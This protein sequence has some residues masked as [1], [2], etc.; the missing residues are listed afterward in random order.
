MTAIACWVNSEEQE[1]VWAVSDSR[2]TQFTSHQQVS[3]LTDHCPKL[4]TIPVSVIRSVDNFRIFPEKIFEF[5]FGFAGSTVIGINVKEILALS[6]SQLN[7]IGNNH[8]GQQLPSDLYPSLNE[9]ADLAKKIAEQY[10]HDLGQYFPSSVR[11][12]MVIYGFCKKTQT[13]KIIK[14]N[15]SS[16]TPAVINI[17][18]CEDLDSGNAILLGDRQAEFREI[19]EITKQ[20]FTFDTINWWR[21]P[22]I[23]LNNWINQSLVSTIGGYIQLSRADI[24]GARISFLTNINENS[25]SMSHAGINT[26]ESFGTTIGQLILMPMQGM[27]LPGEDGWDFGNRVA[28]EVVER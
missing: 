7:E 12:E 6:L 26:T 16:T 4:F 1:S 22:F 25:I 23:A 2:I 19:I 27:S 14:L 9:I 17:V 28:R 3:P 8:Q 5:G 15:N 21:S 24:L 20:R 10:M 18:D 13:H 11:I